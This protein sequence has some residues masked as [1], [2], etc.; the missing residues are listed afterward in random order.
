MAIVSLD[1]QKAHMR[2][3]FNDD[4]AQIQAQ[5]DGAQAHLEQLLGYTIE[6]EFE[7][8]PTDLV[9]AVMQLAAN[10]YENREATSGDVPGVL[11]LG[12]GTLF[13]SG[14]TTRSDGSEPRP[15]AP[16]EGARRH[17]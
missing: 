5:I 11:P 10:W 16:H 17:P 14:G 1:D 8:V 9:Q 3:D 15:C 6:E 12:I 4:D 7:V 13:A 2:V